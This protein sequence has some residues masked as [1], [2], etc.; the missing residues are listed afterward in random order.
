MGSV[1]SLFAVTQFGRRTLLLVGHLGCSVLLA[2]LAL[3]ICWDLDDSKLAVV[4]AYA[5]LFNLTNAT[6]IIVYLVEICTDIALGAALVTMQLVIL[7]ETATALPMI[8]CFGTEG[9][10]L[11]Y[12]GLSFFGFLYVYFFIGETKCLS[13]KGKK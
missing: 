1:L 6:V 2:I 4:C 11:I 9:F 8:D 5:F 10:F 3:T 7:V 13:E 12:S